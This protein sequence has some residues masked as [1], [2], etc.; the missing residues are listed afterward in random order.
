[1]KALADINMLEYLV[2]L[3]VYGIPASEYRDIPCYVHVQGDGIFRDPPNYTVQKY[4]T[5]TSEYFIL[6]DAEDYH[7]TNAALAHTR[8]LV[9]LRKWLG[10]PHFDLE[11]IWE[12]HTY[13]EFEVRSV[14]KT[15]GTMVVSRY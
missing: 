15:M 12:E 8:T 14:A 11:A 10:G 2:C 6:P 5:A 1:M 3:V 13:Y 7:P 4:N 9:F